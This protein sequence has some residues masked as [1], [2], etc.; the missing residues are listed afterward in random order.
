MLPGASA[1]TPTTACSPSSPR[2]IVAA[3]RFARATAGCC[4]A[5]PGCLRVQPRRHARAHVRRRV[6]LDTTPRAQSQRPRSDLDAVLLRSELRC[7]DSRRRPVTWPARPIG[8]MA[9]ASTRSR[10]RTARTWSTR[11]PACFRRCAAKCY[12][13]RLRHQR[14]V[15]VRCVRQL[16]GRWMFMGVPRCVTGDS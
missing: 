7:R 1:S 9:V 16:E 12:C 6:P 4:A 5:D 14:D 11:W 2:T 10:A 8:G 3:S 15:R 13:S